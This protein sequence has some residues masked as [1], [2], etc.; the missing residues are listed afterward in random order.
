[1]EIIDNFLDI[2][3]YNKIYNTL[4]GPFFPWYY[5]NGVNVRVTPDLE[6]HT[7]IAFDIYD[8]QFIHIM[9]LDHIIQSPAF[10]IVVPILQKL[11]AK[12]LLRV[13]AN[14]IPRADK[15]F[16]HGMHTD[17]EF[18]AKT[19]I[20]YVNNNNGYTKFENEK[21]VESIGNRIV[22]FPSLT[23]H[24]GTTCTDNKTRVAININYF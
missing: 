21:I 4:M 18:E 20:F 22:I 7:K 3:S 17:I 12:A 16:E 19:A 10:D 8:F 24:S 13:K 15:I 23:K 1:M 9:Y 5:N 2:D 14:L 6:K 11:D